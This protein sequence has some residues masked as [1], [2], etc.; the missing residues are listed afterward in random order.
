MN[1]VCRSDFEEKL[2]ELFFEYGIFVD[3]LLDGL[4][5]RVDYLLFGWGIRVVSLMGWF[6]V[7]IIDGRDH[8]CEGQ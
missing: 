1:L 6:W 5:F 2:R 3:E 7:G 4:V 8:C